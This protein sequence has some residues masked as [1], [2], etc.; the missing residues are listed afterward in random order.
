[1][2]LADARAFQGIRRIRPLP[3]GVALLVA[4]VVAAGALAVSYA[5]S[6]QPSAAPGATAPPDE[7]RA[8]LLRA[9]PHAGVLD[10]DNDTVPDTVENFLLGSDP[11]RWNTSRT[12]IPDGWLARYG[13][14][15]SEPGLASRPATVPPPDVLPEVYGNRWPDGLVPTLWEIYAYKRPPTWDESV[16]GPWES[17]L[18]PTRWDTNGDG[19]PDAFMLRH[20]LDPL[21]ANVTE[22]R[23]AGPGGLTVRE[24]FQHATD[25]RRV[26]TDGDGVSDAEEIAGPSNPRHPLGPMQFPPSNPRRFDTVGSG[27]CDGYL[28]IHGLDPSRPEAAF[29]D[30]DRDGATTRQEYNWTFLR[31]GDAACSSPGGLDPTKMVSG[32][33][34]IPDGWYLRY[35]LNPL[36]ADVA[37]RV[38]QSA[39]NDP[40]PQGALILPGALP[41][42]SLT[43][44]D[45]YVFGRPADWQEA[46]DGPWWGGTHPGRLDTDGDAI[47]DARE[48]SGYIVQIA[49]EPARTE[50]TAYR[51]HSDPTHSDTDGDGMADGA[52]LTLSSVPNAK[53]PSDPRRMDSDFDGLA[54][55][56]EASLAYGLDPT[57]ADTA[58]DHLRDGARLRLLQTRSSAYAVDPT[59]EYAGPPG[60][61]RKVTD[62]AASLPGAADLPKPLGRAEAAHLLGPTGDA[63]GDKVP[64]VRDRDIDGDKL[65]NGWELIPEL[66]ASSSYGEGPLVT[67]RP[68]T[69]PLNPDT[70]GD[71]LVD[72]WEIKYGL[73]D[74]RSNSY[75]LDPARWDSDGDQTGDAD[76]DY[77]SDT[78]LWYSYAAPGATPEEHRF[79]YPNLLEQQYG[80]NPNLF[81]SDTDGL[82]D[83]WKVFWGIVYP[84]SDPPPPQLP[85]P[86]LRLDQRTV[87]VS[88]ET[89]RR[90]VLNDQA[91]LP[92]ER[93]VGMF[94]GIPVPGDPNR[95]VIEV[96]GKAAWS[97]LEIQRHRTNPYR[98]D[99][100]GD[101][102]PDWWEASLARSWPGTFDAAGRDVGGCTSLG[103]PNATYPD[104]TRDSDRDGLGHGAEWTAKTLPTCADTDL[105]GLEDGR[106][107]AFG[108]DPTDPRDDAA[109]L[110]EDSDGDGLRDFEEL[111]GLVH[112]YLGSVP[113]RT[114]HDKPDT[115]GDGLLDG[116]TQPDPEEDQSGWDLDDPR[117]RRL[118]DL[119]IAYYRA[120]EGG[121]F[122]IGELDRSTDPRNPDDSR[123]GVPAG[124][125]VAHNIHPRLSSPSYFDYYS[126]AMPAWWDH[127][128]H[129]PWWGGADPGVDD[130]DRLR[131][132]SDLDGDGLLDR[133]GTNLYEDPMPSANGPNQWRQ[134]YSEA[135]Q[136][137]WPA[138]PDPRSSQQSPLVRRLVAQAYLN[139]QIIDSQ[140]LRRPAE[141]GPPSSLPSPCLQIQGFDASPA[142]LVKGNPYVLRGRVVRCPAPNEGISGATIEARLGQ[143]PQSFGAAISDA[144]GH[145]SMPF[146]IRQEHELNLPSGLAVFRGNTSGIVRWEAGPAAVRLGAQSIDIRTYSM[147]LSGPAARNPAYGSAREPLSITVSATSHLVL[148]VPSDVETGPPF[149]VSLQLVDSGGAPLRHVVELSWDGTTHRV[150]PSSAGKAT[151][152]L[153]ARHGFVGERALTMRSLPPTSES[154]YATPATA[155]KW[156]HLR[157]P[158]DLSLEAPNSA[159]AGSI[160]NL[161][162]R[163]QAQGRPVFGAEVTAQLVFQ[164]DNVT[165]SEVASGHDGKFTAFLQVPA[166]AQRGQYVLLVR[167][168]ETPATTGLHVSH[169]VN[170]RSKPLFREMALQPLKVGQPFVV[171]G[172]LVEPNDNSPLQDAVVHATIGGATGST[173]TALNGTFIITFNL[174]I[175]PMP[176]VQRVTFDGDAEH[177]EAH[178]E[179]ERFALGATRI[180]IPN[181]AV[182]QGSSATIPIRVVDTAGTGLA[183]APLEVRWAQEPPIRL[184]T[185]AQGTAVF[186]RLGRPG[187]PLG[188]F[189]VEASYN[190]TKEG[191]R[192]PAVGTAT[193]NIRAAVDILLPAGAFTAGTKLPSGLLLD[194][195]TRTPL[196][197]I[198][199]QVVANEGLSR[200][201]STDASG[202]FLVVPT[203]PADAAPATLRI[204]A[205]LPES[206]RYAAA[207]NET[208]I[209]IQSATRISIASQPVFVVGRPSVLEATILDARGQPVGDGRVKLSGSDGQTWGVAPVV[210]GQARLVSMPPGLVSPGANE[211]SIAFG[212]SE[213]WAPSSTSIG[214]RVL[215]AVN[216]SVRIEA[217]TPGHRSQIL[218]TATTTDGPL[219]GA[220]INL[221]FDGVGSGLVAATDE[222]GTV[223]FDV[224]TPNATT[225]FAVRFPGTGLLA[226]TALTASL[227]PATPPTVFSRAL[228]I[229]APAAFLAAVAAYAYTHIMLRMRHPLA[230]AFRRCQALMR[231]RGPLALQIEMAYRILEDAAIGAAAISEHQNTAGLLRDALARQV[232][233]SA[234]PW[235]DSL[236]GSFE[237]VRYS[238]KPVS[239]SERDRCLEALRRIL[240]AL[241]DHEPVRGGPARALEAEE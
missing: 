72:E 197:N 64:N 66:Y 84:G 7:L 29:G 45:E 232:P 135:H 241:L 118:L 85:R 168:A 143:P 105:G 212:D 162:G 19:V 186:V 164:G 43:V 63:N 222:K 36:E 205:V 26:D 132:T 108:L 76:E 2:A 157:N 38:T 17:G 167:V 75:N 34:D 37:S 111:V 125:L 235:L 172:R 30:A 139:P 180:T 59:Y 127:E 230:G 237:V 57:L 173:K 70:D 116:R 210:S 201:L 106:E 177:A 83:G 27:V 123:T 220:P 112:P 20:G 95:Q 140:F 223:A 49:T 161:R 151:V 133:D 183:H 184:L 73:P 218:V 189:L 51:T 134:L 62:W 224:T 44:R 142:T 199:I 33:G 171:A 194:A 78:S 1:M 213:R 28:R 90:Y 198:P 130:L 54:D 144:E 18:D 181:G 69:D 119:G 141:T 175:P 166:D 3:L 96:E 217:T 202:R 104:A 240:H 176:I 103:M 9:A 13:L 16:D 124:W 146:S 88:T 60:V 159:D 122:F 24:A 102:T 211:V 216:L 221:W 80:T 165:E 86:S 79:L 114:A 93:A 47:G 41:A 12:P 107:L 229:L 215:A 10:T 154:A 65:A 179:A 126:L 101:G 149:D 207:E 115:D 170:I 71:R 160:I 82:G 137:Q 150:T 169:L 236:I 120:F 87:V 138:Q 219:V 117:T 89:Y 200:T 32:A 234:W 31:R 188:T 182:A 48:Q 136:I 11:T 204:R 8:G 40:V 147:P 23:A 233:S 187:A 58:G 203:P 25:P 4:I 68:A 193:W 6:K 35:G 152:T 163:V 231:A 228:P 109:T 145:F 208:I 98:S 178:H 206:G 156:I 195:Q 227:V 55:S 77:D 238:E 92:T 50:G 53:S 128:V 155:T 97:F 94:S 226:G 56:E 5:F 67:G 209:L 14:S 190:G 99:T 52:E 61:V 22:F 39:M 21:G 153:A 158:P 100:D 239:E 113:V 15:P 185:D 148:D 196:G 225:A 74:F 174:S 110:D 81:D 131:Q 192:A 121:F 191:G 91:L 129:G 214:A 46:R 42:V